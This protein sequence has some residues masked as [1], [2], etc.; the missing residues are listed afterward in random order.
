MTGIE[1]ICALVPVT[2]Y[3][4]DIELCILRKD[5][6]RRLHQILQEEDVANCNEAAELCAS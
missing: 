1:I 6:K 3:A 4:I 5:L 2:S